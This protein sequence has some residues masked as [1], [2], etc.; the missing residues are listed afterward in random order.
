MSFRR[1]TYPEVL[2]NLLTAVSGGIA[3]EA[4]PFPPDGGSPPY[5]HSLERPP[6]TDVVSLHGSR[7]GQPHLFRK[8]VDYRLLGD[9][10]TVEWKEEA[11]LPDPGTLVHINYYPASAQRVLT[12]IH[13][14]SIVRTLAESAGLEMARLYAALE[15]VYRSAFIDTATARALDNVVAL[16]G[17]TRVRGGRPA[18]SVEFT[19]VQGSR[20]AITVPVGTRVL[21]GDGE[22]EYETTQAVTLADGQATVRVA[23]RD[24][25]ENEGLLAASLTVLAT[26]IAG[27]A[28]VTNPV[29][30]SVTTQ[31]ETDEELR[32]RAK[33]FLHGSERATLGALK[34][35]VARQGITVEIEEVA[36]G[37]VKVTPHAEEMPPEL[38]QRLLTAIEDVRPVG[39]RVT[40]GD[41]KPPQR[42]NLTLRLSTR[43]GLL[44]Q[45]LRA[46]QRTARAEIADYFDRLPARE[47]GSL[48]RL[49]GLL[50]AIPEVEDVRVLTATA[51]V[52]GTTS[53]VLDREAGLLTIAGAPTVLGELHIADP[54]LPTRLSVIVSAPG[55]AVPPD[56]VA[57]RNAMS[58]TVSY[59]NELNASEV[60]A[61]AT[62]AEAAKRVISYGKL[63]RTVPLPNKPGESLE[64]YDAA[65][66]GNGAVPALPTEAAISPYEVQ[67]VVT[68]ESGLTHILA[69][70]AD[71]AYTLTPFERLSL[72]GVEVA[73]VA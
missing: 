48:N 53:D 9:G 52:N 1:R 62:V 6:V 71:G 8:D 68:L 15:G 63:L 58:T 16:L 73:T 60:P 44:E 10:Q 59:L 22:V 61:N 27:I 47:A 57:I 50:L 43:E 56:T 26:P 69:A 42:V 32:A 45:D 12:D 36:P 5:R 13:T 64:S 70:A 3:A 29:P 51:T 41:V 19:R 4:H 7:D 55:N 2:E 24:L 21:T 65:T 39:V 40:V 14:G 66:T 35:A 25:E 54:G 49:V 28:H 46:V 33:A 17:V 20:G 37:E 34:Q 67:F 23:A 18:G 30:T 31:D 38:Q 72:G 11:E